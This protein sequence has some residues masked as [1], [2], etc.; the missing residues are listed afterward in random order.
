V[1]WVISVYF[2]I[3]N[4]LPKSGTFL[5]G[6]PVCGCV[7]R[8]CRI[9]SDEAYCLQ[10]SL[11]QCDDRFMGY[12]GVCFYHQEGVVMLQQFSFP[13]FIKFL[14]FSVVNKINHQL[15]VFF[16]PG[17]P[18]Q[19]TWAVRKVS[20]HFEY[21]E[22]RS[23]GLDVTWQPVRGDLNCASMNSHSPMGLVSRQ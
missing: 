4:T 5:L 21:L 23:R 12:C 3:R 2:N 17:A 8:K 9:F 22:N 19:N 15:T 7:V 20:G 6:H 1:F 11:L 18:H 13:P 14:S 10:Q 16:L